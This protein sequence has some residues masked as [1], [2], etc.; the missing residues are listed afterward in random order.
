MPVLDDE[1]TIDEVRD[2]YNRLKP[3]KPT[4]DGWVKD[5]VTIDEVRDAY[6]R[7]KPDKPTGDGWVK[8]EITID[9]VRDAIIDLNLTN[10]LEM[11]GL[12]MKSLLMK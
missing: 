7:L 9:E 12:R 5:E 11:D 1:V 2:A 10:L 4:G 6:N 8:D 3:D